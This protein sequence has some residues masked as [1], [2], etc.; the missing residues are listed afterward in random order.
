MTEQVN[1][2]EFLIGKQRAGVVAQALKASRAMRIVKLTDK[3]IELN[4]L[5]FHRKKILPD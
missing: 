4:E 1:R 3:H 5:N 2:D